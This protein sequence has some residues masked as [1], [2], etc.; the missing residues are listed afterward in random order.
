[1]DAALAMVLDSNSSILR[2]EIVFFFLLV[3]SLFCDKASAAL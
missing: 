3:F 2:Y 1:M